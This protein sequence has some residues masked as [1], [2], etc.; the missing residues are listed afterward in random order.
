MNQRYIETVD[1]IKQTLPL[2]GYENMIVEGWLDELQAKC[3][4]IRDEDRRIISFALISKMLTDP[5]GLLKDPWCLNFIYTHP[6]H[7]LRGQGSF[8]LKHL[9]KEFEMSC[10]PLDH[11]FMQFFVK[12]GFKSV[13]TRIGGIDIDMAYSTI[14]E[15]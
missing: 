1:E 5:E 14:T 10:C 15:R 7:R 4:L 6:E 13:R 11:H 12:N 8:L 3:F 9:K 2:N